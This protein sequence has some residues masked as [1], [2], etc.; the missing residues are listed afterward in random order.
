L[1]FEGGLVNRDGKEV[2]IMRGTV[3]ESALAKVIQRLL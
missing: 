2:K 3:S 1:G